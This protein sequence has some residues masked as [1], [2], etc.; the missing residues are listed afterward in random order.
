M[1]L[2]LFSL[3]LFNVQ[4]AFKNSISLQISQIMS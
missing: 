2:K 1:T 4:L 3:I